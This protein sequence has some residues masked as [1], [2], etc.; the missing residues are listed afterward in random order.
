VTD[1]KRKIGPW[2]LHEELGSGGNATVWKA[3]R[4]GADD[5][6]ALKV[7]NARRVGSEPYQRF[8]RET[9]F[10][11]RIGPFAGVLPVIDAYLPEHS[12]AED[13]PWLAMRIA[14]RLDHALAGQPLE[15]VVGALAA[16]GDTLSRL[17]TEHNV[18]HRDIKPSNLFELDG[19][20][21]VGDFGLVALP[22]KEELALTGRP[23]GSRHYTAYEMI[24]NPRNADP[25]PA[26]VYSLGKTLWVLATGQAYPPEGHQ[27]SGTRQFSIADFRPHPHATLLDQLVDRSTLIHPDE[28]PTMRE[29][30]ADLQQWGTLAAEPVVVD[31]GDLRSRLRERMASQLAAEDLLE[32][33]QELAMASVRRM[34]ELF[35]PLN[36]ALKDVHP[37]AEIDATADQYTQTILSTGKYGGAPEIVFRFQ[38]LSRITSGPDFH[39]FA[40]RLGR[41]LELTADGEL[42]ARTYLDVGFPRLSGYSFDWQSG[43]LKAPVGSVRAEAVLAELVEQTALKLREAIEAFVENVP[44]GKN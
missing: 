8:V 29:I 2:T 14:T 11:R 7:I 44:P 26:D 22:D 30:A 6:V 5:P 16:I 38:R 25:L 39:T 13:R 23:I 12:T 36:A 34:T 41:S 24:V 9:E 35:K 15:I 20:F 31:L 1:E 10:L 27:T 37:R 21:L 17:A 43:A 19:Q 3:T 40:L 18:G 28:R 4:V 42:V 32:Q 33:R